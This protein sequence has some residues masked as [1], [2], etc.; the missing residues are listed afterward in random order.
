[1]SDELF[2]HLIENAPFE[3]EFVDKEDNYHRL[4]SYIKKI[5]DDFILIDQPVS[6]EDSVEIPENSEVNL[7]FTRKDGVLIATS[8]VQTIVQTGIRVGFPHNTD[9][10]ERRNLVRVPLK[11]GVK[12]FYRP[13]SDNLEEK[14]F[15]VK[16]RNISG[17]GVCFFS[18]YSLENASDIRCKIEL[19]DERL[20]PVLVKCQHVYSRKARLK[21]KV[22]YLT[23]L[24]YIAISD[25]DSTRIVKECFKYQINRKHLEQ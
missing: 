15:S 19:E 4:K 1:M 2:E 24:S 18:S 10:I 6:K 20:N 3:I 25:E 8:K 9:I 22:C 23:A 7:I 16:T 12:V 5:F 14:N 17:N 13:D 21:E 11:T